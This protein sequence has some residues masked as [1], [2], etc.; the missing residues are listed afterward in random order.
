L[1][2]VPKTGHALPPAE[3]TVQMYQWLESNLKQRQSDTA[4]NPKLT[5]SPGEAPTLEQQA[6]CLLEAAEAAL[7]KP[8]TTWRGVALL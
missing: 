4:N 3:L 6:Q 7:Q 8:G 1:W 2:I 5:V